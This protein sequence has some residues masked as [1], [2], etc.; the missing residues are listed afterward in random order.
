MSKMQRQEEI[1]FEGSTH[2]QHLLEMGVQARPYTQ[3]LIYGSEIERIRVLDL[4]HTSD[5]IPVVTV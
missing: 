1:G 2:H 5:L 4:A 3:Q